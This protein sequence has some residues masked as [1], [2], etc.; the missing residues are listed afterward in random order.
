LCERRN[1]DAEWR[2]KWFR[3]R[4]G[5]RRAAGREHGCLGLRACSCSERVLEKCAMHSLCLFVEDFGKSR[6]A[7]CFA[8]AASRGA[9]VVHYCLCNVAQQTKSSCVKSANGHL[10]HASRLPVD[11][12]HGHLGLNSTV[13]QLQSLLQYCSTGLP[14]R[15]TTRSLHH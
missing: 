15:Q 6:A 3:G 11:T 12:W 13:L 14:H 1:L 9:R 8:P 5:R 2:A 7:S 10:L 4:Q